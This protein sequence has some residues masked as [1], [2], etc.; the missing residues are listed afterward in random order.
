VPEAVGAD[1]LVDPALGGDR[2]HDPT[3]RMAGPCADRR[4]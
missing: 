4:R 1:V 2:A 3:C